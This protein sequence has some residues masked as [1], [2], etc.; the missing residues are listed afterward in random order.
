MKLLLDT[1]AFLWHADG[2]PQM[3]ATATALAVD[4]A[5]EL[6][7]SMASV[8]EIAIKV[9]MK[10]LTVSAPYVTFMTRAIAGYGVS[11]LPVMFD[12]C[13][14]YE[15]LPFPN[16][17]HRDPFD[18]MIIIHALRDGLSIVGVDVSFDAYG[19]TRLW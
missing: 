16:K 15:R 12:D 2:S 14:A 7:L 13:I 4:P 11:V 6:F 3:S 18:R 1:H 8:W 9:G 19:I 5:N 17:Q 10:K